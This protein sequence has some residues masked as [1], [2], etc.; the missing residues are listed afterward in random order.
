M[1]RIWEVS[2]LNFWR[3]KNYFFSSWYIVASNTLK[4]SFFDVDFK[5]TISF[6]VQHFIVKILTLK[7]FP[8]K[9]SNLKIPRFSSFRNLQ[10]KLPSKILNCSTLDRRR[11][12][13]PLLPWCPS[14]SAYCRPIT[15]IW[16]PNSLRLFPHHLSSVYRHLDLSLILGRFFPYIPF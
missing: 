13:K 16:P 5:N 12:L 6:Y 3:E 10:P 8:A 4:D 9:N 11:A 2:N 15:Q 14:N 1:T 7:D